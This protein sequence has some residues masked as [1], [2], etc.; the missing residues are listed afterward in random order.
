MPA[1]RQ[2]TWT[3]FGDL[4]AVLAELVVSAL[5]VLKDRPGP[6][7]RVRQPARPGSFAETRAFAEAA[8]AAAMLGEGW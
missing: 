7:Q 3:Q 1:P 5:E 6:W 8:Q 2:G 4:N